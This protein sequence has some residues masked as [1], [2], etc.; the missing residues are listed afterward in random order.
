MIDPHTHLG[1]F[2]A[3]DPIIPKLRRKADLAGWRTS[4]P[5][6]WDRLLQEK[7]TN[8]ADDLIAV[9]DKNDIAVSLV[10]PTPNVSTEFVRAAA[11]R[12]PKRLIP[13]GQPTRWPVGQRPTDGQD[14]A[15]HT[16][17]NGERSG[18]IAVAERAE[19]YIR[20]FGLRAMGELNPA[21]ITSAAHPDDIADDFDPLMEVLEEYRVPFQILTAWTQFPG[22]LF[23]GDPIWVDE[24]ANRHPTVPMV[25][26]KMGRG[27]Q[28]YFDA[29]LVV[30]MRNRNVFLDTAGTTP[31]HLRVALDVLGPERIMFATDWTYTWR[32]MR[33]PAD[34]HSVSMRL[35]RE[36]VDD[37]GAFIQ[38]MQGTAEAVFASAISA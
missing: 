36:A 19:F 14:S 28:R 20:E 37:D 6:V 21:D 5:D 17:G 31:D 33:E 18:G 3:I 8:N 1:A 25:L 27:I 4:Y 15:P 29:A 35:I 12:Y 7:P 38:M 13:M 32:H 9:M 10:Q 30:A 22:A 11:Q 24:I 23:Y 26:T 34:V 2:S 16:Q